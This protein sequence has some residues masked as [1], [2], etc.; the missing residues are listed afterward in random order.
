MIQEENAH[1]RSSYPARS[2][3]DVDGEGIPVVPEAF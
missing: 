3:L 2:A 1:R